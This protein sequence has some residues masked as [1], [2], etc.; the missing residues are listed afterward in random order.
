MIFYPKPDSTRKIQ[1]KAKKPTQPE[2]PPDP[3]RQT[4]RHGP[5]RPNPVYDPTLTRP[6]LDSTRRLNMY[7]SQYAVVGVNDPT[8]H[9]GVTHV[10]LLGRTTSLIAT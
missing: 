4:G 2:K 8:A 3:T 9:H 7:S 5:I 1:P 6:E 10:M